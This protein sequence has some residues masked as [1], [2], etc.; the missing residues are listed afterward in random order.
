MG[1]PYWVI[2]QNLVSAMMFNEFIMLARDPRKDT[3]LQLGIEWSIYLLIWFKN[4]SRG[5]FTKT[6]L[7]KSGLNKKDYPLLHFAFYDYRYLIC[8]FFCIL[9]TIVFSLS[10]K[11]TSLRY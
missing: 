8:L 7:I 6:I 9:I 4:A 5:L 11:R 1:A 2:N 3:Y 10:L